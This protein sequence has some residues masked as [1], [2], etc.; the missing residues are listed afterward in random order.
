MP[1]VD[2]SR[3]ARVREI[4]AQGEREAKSAAQKPGSKGC[5]QEEAAP[6]LLFRPGVM[7]MIAC[8]AAAL[9]YIATLGFGFVY[10]DVPQILK[11]PAIQSWR[12]VPQYFT[13][14]VWAAIYPN[15]AGSYYRPIFL[16]WLRLNYALFGT[17][18]AGW[19]ATSVA[20]HVV[21]TWLVFR[22]AKGLSRDRITAL[23]AA[24]IFAVHPAHVENV[25]WISAVTDPLM[26]CFLLGSFYAFLTFRNSRKRA[27]AALSIGL[28]ALALLSKETAVVL[29]LLI[30]VYV[31][32]LGGNE[33]EGVREEARE[34][35]ESE[36]EVQDGREGKRERE[37]ESGTKEVVAGKAHVAEG[38]SH[39]L[40]SASSAA[41][42]YLALV[43]AYAIVRFRALQGWSHATIPIGWKSVFL[44]W[45]SVLWFYTKH[46]ALPLK[47]S[48][49][50]S[51]DYV[52]HFSASSVLLPATALAATAF[53][54]FL[55]LHWFAREDSQKRLARFALALILLP[56]LP[57][58]DLRALT[59]GDVVHDRYL[60]LP[61]IGFA[62]LIALLV[63]G[64][65]RQIERRSP[66]APAKLLALAFVSPILIAYSALTISQ[67]MQWANDIL[68]YTRG[69]ESAPANLTVRDN[70]ANSLLA[71]NQPDRAIP[72]Y[73]EVLHRNP[74]FWRSNYNLGFAYYKTANFQS[75]ED[76]LHRAIR[77][78][79]SDSDQ[80]IYLALAELQLQHLP[81][82]ADN[83]RQA[84]ARSPH[85]RGYHSVLA[86]IYE[87]SGDR[88]SAAAELKSE[89]SEHPDNAAAVGALQKLE[90]AAPRL[91]S[92]P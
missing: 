77:V 48:E 23:L 36:R 61:S 4:S 40:W 31:L 73:L 52:S 74:D 21:A 6:S 71:A 12:F 11:N 22:I 16:L 53:A 20:C 75:A 92:V 66:T 46:A 65:I 26:T 14:H 29:P 80:Y 85:A 90:E 57:V 42:P 69:L 78:D 79:P 56:L 84:I 60:Y 54:L 63:R 49:F 51:L 30:F 82:A 32:I 17:D 43:L 45:P 10:D 58:L 24:L 44:T 9:A 83:A 55:L 34:R 76:Y 33:E 62:L 5:D 1:D 3:P 68:L 27:T 91:S 70:L 39:R 7:A 13:S 81:E 18:A 50:Y 87:T 67:Q 8:A 88:A 19:H 38:V 72:L 64:M 59:V 41:F 47:S 86:L 35:E 37:Q 15:S 89:I 25:A 2:Q 28:F